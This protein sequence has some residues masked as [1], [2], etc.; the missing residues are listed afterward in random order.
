MT[1]SQMLAILTLFCAPVLTA[2]AQTPNVRAWGFNADG[3]LGNGVDAQ[4]A[5]RDVPVQVSNL[6][7]VAAIAAGANHSLALGSDG[8]VWAWGDDEYGQLGNGT[9]V[10]SS[11]PVQVSGLAGV[12]A[13]AAGWYHSLALLNNGTVWAWGEN[14]YGGLGN[15]NNVN[16]DVPVQVSGLTGV[17]AIAAGEGFSLALLNNGTLWAW[18]YNADGELGNGSNVNS[19]VP[20]QVSGLSTVT[21]IAAGEQHGLAL[22]SKG[23]VWAWGYNG[24]GELGDGHYTNSNVPVQVSGLNDM[25]AI[26]AGA[27]HS[28]ALKSGG[29]V[30]AWGDDGG[31]ELGNASGKDS[32]VPALVSA[33]TGG[34]TAIAAGNEYSLAIENN[35]SVWAWGS[36]YLGQLG[37]GSSS[38]SNVL[39]PVEVSGLT[40]VMA[41]AARADHSVALKSDG[42]VWAWGDNEYGELGIGSSADSNVPMTVTGLTDVVSIADAYSHAFALK[43]DGTVWAWGNNLYGELGNGSYSTDSNVPTQVGLSDVVAI[44]GGTE[45]S[46]ALRSDGTVW[47]WGAILGNGSIAIND[48]LVTSDVPVQVN[49]LSGVAAIAAG[50]GFSMVVKADGTVWTWGIPIAH[51]TYPTLWSGPAGVVA[52][53]ALDYA[54]LA[55]KADGTVWDI[56][57]TTGNVVEI[58]GLTGVVAIAGGGYNNLA[59]K[60]DGTVWAWG[61]GSGRQLGD[62]VPVQ[63][64]GLTGVVAIAAGEDHSLALKNDGTV[65]AWGSN[66]YGQLGDGS[67]ADSSVPV[68]IS[69]LSRVAAIAAGNNFSL[70]LLPGGSPALTAAPASLSFGTIT[71]GSA[72]APQTITISNDGTAPVA[73]NNVIVTGVNPGDFSISGTC[74]GASLAQAQTCIIKVTFTPAAPGSR[75]AAVILTAT[76]TGS[77]ILVMLS[78]TGTGQSSSGAPSISGVVSASAFGA[79]SSVAPGSWVEIYGTNLAPSTQGWTG[80]DFKGNNAPTSLGGVSVSIG[81]QAAFIDYI[82]PTQVNAQLPSNIATGGTLQLTVTNPN[83][84]SAAVNIT[85]NMTEPGLLAPASFKIG[86][87]QYV[88]AQHSDGSYVLPVGAI[89]G[90]ASSPAKPGEA[91]VI[92]GVGFGSVV[93]NIL[94]GEIATVTN[95]LSASLQILFGKTAAKLPYSGL[96]PNFVGLYQFNVT[97]PAV[98]DNDL[99]PLT[100]NLGSV[101]GTQTLFTAVHQ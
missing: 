53:S 52:V 18:G 82:S 13:I 8:T 43:S 6:T 29:S 88:V 44:A 17:V 96:A 38:G 86:G 47:S 1:K 37:N 90:V 73:I 85:V 72:S 5:G 61:I 66:A 97:V 83:G 60:S 30:W 31:D 40:G 58:S 76:A 55:L 95:Q 12:V 32:N 54:G 99:V 51:V 27:S 68:Q 23:A 93:P 15:G 101:A 77:P 7:G 3:E 74:S 46:L 4:S 92:Y 14:E 22:L 35:G 84:A 65:W 100:F 57:R 71:P 33:L 34:A 49:N 59:L 48:V 75:S 89:T 11:L 63:V 26:A 78:G 42:T 36:T 80:A 67:N 2:L 62:G 19:S 16:S 98:A 41:I 45:G 25:T 24:D 21:A 50:S 9:N 91:I 70:A 87:N 10:T 64:N 28:L 94:A 69:G 79:F 39:A 56:D 20:V 81:G